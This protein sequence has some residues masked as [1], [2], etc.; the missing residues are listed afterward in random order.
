MPNK[1]NPMKARLRASFA[2]AL[3]EEPRLENIDKEGEVL[4]GVQITLEGEAKG[5]GVWLDR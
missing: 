1:F 4:H 5:H 2:A 3:T